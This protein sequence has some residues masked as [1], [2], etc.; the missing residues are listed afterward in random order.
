MAFVLRA[1]PQT[2]AR[3]LLIATLWWGEFNVNL[4]RE[5]KESSRLLTDQSVQRT[6]PPSPSSCL[7]W[8][9]PKQTRKPPP[10]EWADES[11]RRQNVSMWCAESLH[12]FSHVSV[13]H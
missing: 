9:R 2:G 11:R 10:T 12:L 1:G 3:F 13:L 5:V 7:R 4:Y 8:F 6:D